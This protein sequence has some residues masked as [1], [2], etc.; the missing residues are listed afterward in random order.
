VLHLLYARFFTKVIRDLGL[1]KA[2]EPFTNLLTQGMVIK[3]GAKMSKSKGNVVDPDQIIERY[4]ADTMRIFSL[5]AA[6]PEKDLE[7]SDQAVEG[8][9]RFLNR[10]WRIVHE[11]AVYPHPP[12]AGSKISRSQNNPDRRALNAPVKRLQQAKHRTIQK[13][14]DDLEDHFQFNTAIAALM[15]FYNTITDVTSERGK[16]AVARTDQ[17]AFNRALTEALETLIVLLSPFAPH[18]AEG[19]WQK[20]GHTNSLVKQ[21]WPGYDE[22]MLKTEEINIPVQVNG[23]LRSVLTVPAE[24][25]E[26]QIRERALA[27]AKI[28]SWLRGKEIAKIVYVQ[29]RLLNIVVR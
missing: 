25:S 22:A 14:T 29:G 11:H 28:A 16:T 9:N 4:G 23:K 20:L 24:S 27:D 21:P 7:W 2:G 5:F 8:A 15:E 12:K 26:E 3:D 19:L 18:I 1:L 10:V 17:V 13:V 6:P